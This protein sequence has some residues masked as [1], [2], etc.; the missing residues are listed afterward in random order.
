M[1]LALIQIMADSATNYKKTEDKLLAMLEAAGKSGADFSVLPECTYPGYMA[2]FN[3]EYYYMALKENEKLLEKIAL[4]ARKYC[5][6]IAVGLAE[7]RDKGLRNA[8][9][10]FNQDGEVIHRT[11]K[12]NLWHFDHKCF[13]PGEEFKT[14]D[15]P[16]GKMGMIICAD[17]RIPEISRILALDGAKMIIDLVNLTSYAVNMKEFSNPQQ[18]YYINVRALE[19]KVW[20]AVCGKMGVEDHCVCN[21]GKSMVVNPLGEY[22][23]Q[24]PSDEE[25][26]LYCDVDLTQ[27]YGMPF[28]RNPELYGIITQENEA[29][30]VVQDM[31]LPLIP[32]KNQFYTSSVQFQADDIH[33]YEEKAKRYIAMNAYCDGNVLFLPQTTFY[34]EPKEI[35]NI[36][37]KY[38]QDEIVIVASKQEEGGKYALA[39]D[40]TGIIG[41]WRATK[42]VDNMPY[43]CVGT[44]FGKVG[45]IFD[46]ELYIPEIARCYML[47]GC[48]VLFVS[49]SKKRELDNKALYTRA[50]EN[51]MYIIRNSSAQED[52]STIVT[53]D[54]KASA[55]S[56]EGEEQIICG[57]T[58]PVL[59]LAKGVV[60]GTDAVM[61]RFGAMYSR[62]LMNHC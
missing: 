7:Y 50:S 56:L 19:N 16:W 43:A 60:P 49:D 1:K 38:I 51:K 61:N 10:V 6:F 42:E 20:F 22:V 31:N 9:I 14:F 17:G 15:T 4:I 54:G 33:G 8:G 39:L 57:Y 47:M 41:I 44:K 24:L 23:A 28:R 55:V 5:M 11:F 12:S 58:L 59:S 21:L 29:L 48:H 45:V 40:K 2:G 34:S 53:P 3:S 13:A 26:I 27:D 37:K 25:D 32:W 46:H 36:V 30:P 62:L 35:C 52:H 18:E